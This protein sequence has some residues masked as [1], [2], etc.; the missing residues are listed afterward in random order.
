MR[1]GRVQASTLPFD[2]MN[3]SRSIASLQGT[4]HGSEHRG[5]RSKMP[6]KQRS[7]I[8][9]SGAPQL[10]ALRDVATV[11]REDAARALHPSEVRFGSTASRNCC[12]VLLPFE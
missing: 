9:S 2:M 8:V 1:L 4:Q 6:L 10:H 3:V 12:S 7:T 5:R 11:K